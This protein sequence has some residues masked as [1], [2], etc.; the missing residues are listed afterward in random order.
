ML[1]KDSTMMMVITDERA[2][3][4]MEGGATVEAGETAEAAT[5]L[6]LVQIILKSMMKMTKMIVRIPRLV[7]HLR[8]KI[9]PK[10]LDTSSTS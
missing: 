9:A 5:D 8:V 2:A 6:I 7:P 1:T 4:I 10:M 3:Q